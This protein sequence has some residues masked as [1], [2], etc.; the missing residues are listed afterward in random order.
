MAGLETLLQVA[1]EYD[2]S[3]VIVGSSCA[4]RDLQAEL[5]ELA[6]EAEIA[7][8]RVLAGEAENQAAHLLRDRRASPSRPASEH[9]PA[10][11]DEL[12]GSREAWVV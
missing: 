8:A 3:L 4:G 5:A 9:G 7:P 11:T 2:A 1:D 12:S 10:S 6:L